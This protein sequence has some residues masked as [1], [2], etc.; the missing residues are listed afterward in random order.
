MSAPSISETV[1]KKAGRPRLLDDDSIALVAS[2]ATKPVTP[3]SHRN[4][5]HALAATMLLRRF[6]SLLEALGDKFRLM[7]QV[8]LAIDA[9]KRQADADEGFRNVRAQ[10]WGYYIA[11]LAAELL[12][13]GCTVAEAEA[14]L[15]IDRRHLQDGQDA[16]GNAVPSDNYFEDA[17]AKW[18]E[19]SETVSKT[20]EDSK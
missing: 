5:F 13:E 9:G 14:L 2:L 8:G 18:P 4:L 6:P 11:T 20:K 3:R 7:V 17:L 12:E 16:D 15:R 19:V 1:S 10:A